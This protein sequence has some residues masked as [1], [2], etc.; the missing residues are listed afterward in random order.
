MAF[1]PLQASKLSKLKTSSISKQIPVTKIQIFKLRKIKGSYVWGNDKCLGT[2][3]KKAT[4]TYLPFLLFDLWFSN[5][6]SFS[7]VFQ[8]RS[9]EKSYL[10]KLNCYIT[11]RGYF[12]KPFIT[13]NYLPC[14]YHKMRRQLWFIMISCSLH[15]CYFSKENSVLETVIQYFE[16]PN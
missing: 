13:F 9:K 12:S 8:K 5:Y 4:F 14:L 3:W 1:L 2:F 6:S 10:L 15:T 16:H 7:V 11:S